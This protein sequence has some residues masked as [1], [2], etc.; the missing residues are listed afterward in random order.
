MIMLLL[1]LQAAL[2]QPGE[3]RTFDDWTVGCDNGR[4]CRAVSLIAEGD[5]DA[6]LPMMVR[7]DAGPE[8]EPVV[9]LEGEEGSRLVADGRV[10]PVRLVAVDGN[11]IAHPADNQLLVAEL[12]AAQRLE[13]RDAGGQPIGRVSLAGLNAAMLYM[14][15]AQG[16]LDTATAFVRRGARPASAVPAAPALPEVRL[17]APYQDTA[18]ELD[19]A[20]ITALRAEHGC[21]IDEIGGPDEFSAAQLETGKT[22][23]LL[24]CGSGAYNVTNIPFVAEQRDGRLSIRRARFDGPSDL[25]DA[26]LTNAEWDGGRRL[27]SE[28]PRARGLGDCGTR[29]EYAWDGERF[30]LVR[31]EEMEECRGARNFIT[32]WRARVVRP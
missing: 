10:L 25:E 16:R 7:R 28:F 11:R 23:I 8:A 15:E 19:E 13:L 4:A 6:N 29:S 12:R 24:A 3:L 18:P 2:A 20:R 5:W 17:T 9:I 22:L 30:R 32:T 1:A 14:D 31:R 21:T 27:L 26:A